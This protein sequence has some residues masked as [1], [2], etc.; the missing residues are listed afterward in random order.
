MP[1]SPK[2][3]LTIP[4]SQAHSGKGAA[5][6]AQE[7]QKN[8]SENQQS[9]QHQDKPRRRSDKIEGRLTL[10]IRIAARLRLNSIQENLTN[11]PPFVQCGD[12]QCSQYRRYTGREQSTNCP[13]PCP[14]PGVNGNLRITVSVEQNC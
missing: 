13:D 12:A 6:D 9:D 7:N 4:P 5:N 1:S 3:N 10:G 2:C 8:H 11:F 14:H